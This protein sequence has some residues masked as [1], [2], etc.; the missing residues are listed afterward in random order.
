V[1][2]GSAIAFESWS[3]VFGAGDSGQ[4]IAAE[5][6]F[7]TSTPPDDAS[8]SPVA[9]SSTPSPI[10]ANATDGKQ[11]AEPIGV[12]KEGDDSDA[13]SSSI[14]QNNDSGMPSLQDLVVPPVENAGVTNAVSSG[15]PSV[16]PQQCSFSNLGSSTPRVI[17][18]EIAWMGTVPEPGETA[19]KA[20]NQEWIEIKNIS[21]AAIDLDGWQ[22]LD[23]AGNIKIVFGVGDQISAGALYLLARGSTPLATGG[24]AELSVGAGDM[25]R[26]ILPD[27]TYS[28]SLPNVGDMLAVFDPNCGLSDMLDASKGWPAGDNATKQTLERKPDGSGWQTSLSPGG[29]PR[30]ENSPGAPPPAPTSTVQYPV[31]VTI[32]G[33]AP[34]K[35]TGKPAGI[36]CGTICTFQYASGTLLT[37]T[38]SP[39]ANATFAGWSGACSGASTCS[40][41]VGGTMYVTA[42]FQLAVSGDVDADT[43]APDTDTAMPTG[44]SIPPTSSPPIASDDT[45]TLGTSTTFADHVVIAAVQIAGASSTNDFVGLYNLTAAPVD[46]SGWK[47]HKKSSTGADYSLRDFPNGAIIPPQKYFTWANSLGGFAE[48]V[49]ADVSSTETLAADNSVALFDATG[50]LIDAVAWGTGTNQY[51]MGPPYPTDPP[52]NEVLMRLPGAS[53]MVDT[54]NN[55]EDFI[56][57]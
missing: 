42:Q 2:Q 26:D 3:E 56:L 57:P 39:G 43:D 34:G 20:S 12:I 33:D 13:N 1:K 44:E 7:T 46:M 47:L 18:N 27:K 14:S 10:V 37:L 49:G 36:A 23:S 35:V 15:S 17:L 31:G 9:S 32:A 50:S 21:D 19:A 30:A 22:I 28:G 38:A 45:L 6:D 52:A 8:A 25:V 24:S 48:S 11:S 4:P 29:T 53:G 51:G 16:A 41:I 40:F 54:G 5:V 55:A